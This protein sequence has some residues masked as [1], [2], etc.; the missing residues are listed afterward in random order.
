MSIIL[1]IDPGSRITGYGIIKEENRK[2]SYIDSGCI[3]TAEG[4][5]SQRLLEIFDGICQLMD[6]YCPNDVAIEQVF[7]HQNPS[8]ALKLGHAR[9]VAMVA[10]ASHR[11]QVSEYSAREIKQAV[12][13]YGAAQKA[14]VKHMVVNLLLLNSPPQNDAADALA[15]AICHS[16]MR[17]G[18]AAL[19]QYRQ[20]SR[21]RAR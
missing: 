1:G 21:R 20:G 5:L 8:S 13:G 19:P 4:P 11:V 3:R 9:G 7:M 15:I 10:A 14:Q 2:L 17:H 18:L 6:D 16:H 12:V